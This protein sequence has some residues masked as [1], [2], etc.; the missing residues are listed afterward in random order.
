M[1]SATTLSAPVPAHELHPE[2]NTSNDL[3]ILQSNEGAQV[4]SGWMTPTPRDTP[5]SEMRERYERDGYIWVKNVIPRDVVLDMRENYFTALLPTKILAP[6][7]SPRDGIFNP[8]NDPLSYQGI[9]GT[10]DDVISALLDE[11]HAAPY[12]REFLAHEDLRKFVRE[13]MGWEREVLV[14]RAM[15]RHN[16]PGGRST[17]VH[18]DK[19]FLRGS[20]T[21]FLTAWVPIGDCSPHG[22]GLMYLANSNSLGESLEKQF[23]AKAAHLSQEER[24]SAFNECMNADG[25]LSHNAGG[26]VREIGDGGN[27]EGWKWLV[28]DYAAGD[29]VFHK[30]YMVHAATRNVDERG[31]IRLASDLRFYEDGKGLDERWRRVWRHDD[32]L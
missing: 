30:P 7:T 17:G 6:S 23:L 20:P 31:R 26:F 18:Y 3:P 24:E 5:L 19:Y 25:F 22:G 9:G 11:I 15:L 13:F 29:V 32:G 14:E 21:P 28:G 27:G 12:Y 10:P 8:D 2:P 16:V 1:A 4:A